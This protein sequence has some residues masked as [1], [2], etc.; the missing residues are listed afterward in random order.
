MKTID[1]QQGCFAADLE[2]LLRR[3]PVPA[4][5]HDA[6]ATILRDVEQRG[7][8]AI[9]E[10]AAKF[11]KVDLSPDQFQLTDGEIEAA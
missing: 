8:A 9:S 2:Q 7:D 5:I 3:T 4:E 6:V 11:D 10:Y 1:Y